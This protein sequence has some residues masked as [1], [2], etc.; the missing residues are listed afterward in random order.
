MDLPIID[1][2][3]IT[4]HD[5]RPLFSHTSLIYPPLRAAAMLE[6]AWTRVYASSVAPVMLSSF[7]WLSRILANIN[8]SSLLLS[9]YL[10]RPYWRKTA[11]LIKHSNVNDEKKKHVWIQRVQDKYSSQNSLVSHLLLALLKLCKPWKS[12]FSSLDFEIYVF[13]NTLIT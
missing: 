12:E 5:K 11:W 1:T 13:G 6:D 7:H 10:F 3:D 8:E 9:Q 2:G 4:N